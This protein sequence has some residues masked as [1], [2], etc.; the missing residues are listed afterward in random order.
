MF[1]RLGAIKI[2][3]KNMFPESTMKT[4]KLILEIEK[5]IFLIARKHPVI[6]KGVLENFHNTFQIPKNLRFQIICKVTSINFQMTQRKT[7][8][9]DIK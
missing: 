8:K 5:P 3:K 6:K 4:P 2:V 7:F 9:S 1:K